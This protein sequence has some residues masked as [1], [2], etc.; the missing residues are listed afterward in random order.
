MPAKWPNQ[1]TSGG[2]RPPPPMDGLKIFVFGLF[3]FPFLTDS[4]SCLSHFLSRSDILR[5]VDH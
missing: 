5:I 2:E 1:D 3:D 4:L